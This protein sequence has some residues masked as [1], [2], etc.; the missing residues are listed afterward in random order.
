[1]ETAKDLADDVYDFWSG[2][3][4]D[5][6]PCDVSDVLSCAIDNG[7]LQRLDKETR[8]QVVAEMVKIQGQIWLP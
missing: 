4:T 7:V 6:G 8:A 5:L 2:I 1:M 3:A